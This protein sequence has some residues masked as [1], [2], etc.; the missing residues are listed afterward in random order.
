MDD[1]GQGGES[2]L[3]SPHLLASLP[4]FLFFYFPL[5]C[6]QKEKEKEQEDEKGRSKLQTIL[7]PFPYYASCGGNRFFFFSR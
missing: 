6:S 7:Q 4:S 2:I 1:D 5:F 3:I